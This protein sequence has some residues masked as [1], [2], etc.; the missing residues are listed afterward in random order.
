MVPFGAIWACRALIMAQD[1]EL[2]FFPYVL[3]QTTANMAGKALV[4]AEYEAGFTNAP[5]CNNPY[6]GCV[7]RVTATTVMTDFCKFSMNKVPG[8]GVKKCSVCN[9]AKRDCFQVC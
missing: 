8:G 6:E 4:K 1:A 7:A 3:H 2:A 9:T 5:F